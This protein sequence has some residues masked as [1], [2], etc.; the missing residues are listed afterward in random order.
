MRVNVAATV[1]T[2]VGMGLAV[3]AGVATPGP[4]PDPT[5][6]PV[7]VPTPPAPPA[8]PP[9]PEGPTGPGVG[10]PWGV[11]V[12]SGVGDGSA[13][14]T[15]ATAY[16]SEVRPRLF[17]F[18]SACAR[19]PPAG[20]PPGS[21]ISVDFSGVGRVVQPRIARSMSIATRSRAAT[22]PRRLRCGAITAG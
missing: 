15:A 14:G 18:V 21:T 12:A 11:A 20:A 6:V 16:R 7:P 3:G 17:S 1:G 13:L 4:L 8:P 2:G 22:R 10:L 19:T 9:E 5:P